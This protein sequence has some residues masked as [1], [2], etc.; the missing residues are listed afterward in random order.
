MAT[1]NNLEGK[2]FVFLGMS[3]AG[4]GKQTKF[5]TKF[6]KENGNDFLII[7]TGDLARKLA[8]KNTVISKWIKNIL[9]EGG[10]FPEWLAIHIWLS[11]LEKKLIN[12]KTIII[13]EGTPRK[14]K[15][16]KMV[17]ELMEYLKRPLP[18][19]VY[20]DID[21]KEATRRLLKR[22]R[23]DD[24][25]EAIKE[26]LENFSKSVLPTIKYYGKR[27]MKIDGMGSEKE[28]RNRVLG[29]VSS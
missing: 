29:Y 8:K 19:P 25:P 24:N 17:D 13:F 20:L 11:E 2:T 9:D 10:F 21:N 7:S 27:V 6:L 5:L 23:D 1:K 26:R 22:G 14:V 28:V 12:N 16:A 18:I 3:G 15:E 4:K